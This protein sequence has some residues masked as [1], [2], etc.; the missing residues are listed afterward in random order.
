MDRTEGYIQRT[1]ID[2]TE[3]YIQR[4]RIDR[5]EGYILQASFLLF[6]RLNT[7]VIITD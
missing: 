5:T 1:R 2:R 7:V 3:G 6:Q 4:A